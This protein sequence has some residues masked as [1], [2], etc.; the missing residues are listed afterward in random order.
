MPWDGRARWADGRPWGGRERVARQGGGMAARAGRPRA[1]R[2]RGVRGAAAAA[3]AGGGRG[4][5]A[6]SGGRRHRGRACARGR[7]GAA[8]PGGR[9]D[10]DVGAHPRRGRS[11]PRHRGIRTARPVDA[12][13]RLHGGP[14][15]GRVVPGARA[16]DARGRATRAARARRRARRHGQRRRAP[17]GAGG[18][19]RC[20][21]GAGA[22]GGR[23]VRARWSAA[24][25]DREQDRGRRA[26]GGDR[27]ARDGR[28]AALGG[29]GEVRPRAARPARRSG[30]RARRWLG[31][32][33]LG[34]ERG[35]ATVLLLVIAF[36]VMGGVVVLFGIGSALG[37]R[38]RY[39]RTADLAA[40]AGA[41][42]MRDAYPR[43][44]EAPEVRPRAPNPRH[45]DRD[46][47]LAL[48]R[49]AAVRAAA[50]NG[51]LL[52][53]GDVDFPDRSFAPTSVRVRV[54]QTVSVRV[55]NDSRKRSIVVR[56]RATAGLSPP[57]GAGSFGYA[58]TGS[59]GGY[60]GPL[61][62]RMGNPIR[63]L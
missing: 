37:A 21:G 56:A 6:R 14:C 54:R 33:G 3:G 27:R 28:V 7:A 32:G 8:R 46:E 41:R 44:F 10:R 50:A 13:A 47:Y 20:R 26:L 35:Q 24:C 62:Y 22:R 1:A 42:A 4:D 2:P 51:V 34:R 16:G 57:S 48:G 39:Q 38:G 5:R 59:G 30:A 63:S 45:L 31:A 19:P 11:V 52:S 25:A 15:G 49:S 55:A 58:A 9:G 40:V 60:S 61:A 18:R 43:L 29:G 23:V 17:H 53:S 36:V 12:G